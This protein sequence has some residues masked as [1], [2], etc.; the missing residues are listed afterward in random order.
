MSNGTRSPQEIENDIVRS[1]NRLAATVD[2]LAYRVKPKTIVAR[3]AESARETLNKAV[4]NEHGEPRL[5]V[6]A[7]AAI[8]VVGLTAVAIARRARG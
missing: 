6:I 3:Q 4:K 8:V 2:E 7:P 5:E 1:R